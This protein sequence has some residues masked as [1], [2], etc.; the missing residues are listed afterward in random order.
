MRRA[1]R[2]PLLFALTSLG[3]ACS[4]SPQTSSPSTDPRAEQASPVQDT[5]D[6][7]GQWDVVS[8]EN[9]RPQRLSGT[10][11]AAFADFDKGGVRLRIECNYSSRAGR[12][13]GG[14]FRPAPNDDGIQTQM[15]CGTEREAR[16]SRFFAFF[17][18]SPTIERI[19]VD[20]LRL[21]AD[22]TEL[23]LERPA[24][25]RLANA[26]T[27]AEMQGSW[28]MLELTRYLPGGGHS[29][30]GLSDV[31]GRIVIADGRMSYN[32][33]PQYGVAF[34][35][36]EDGRLIKTGGGDLPAAPR[37]CGILSAQPGAPLMPIMWDVLR[38][39]HANPAV[40]RA[41]KNTLLLSTEDVGLLI[42]TAPCRSLEQSE[43][44]KS[45]TV[46]DCASPTN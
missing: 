22:S 33:C 4:W 32:R 30:G 11:R 17:G 9:H 7:A 37:E 5:A 3:V 16:D 43:D 2:G 1:R 6:I 42:T 19:G 24:L 14:R 34:R 41:D 46:R 15:G 39:L 10:T 26:P 27:P 45:S 18:K 40:E 44:H 38:L 36:G 12:V 23:F 20:R 31:P 21:R 13:D 35:I 25:R 29:G 28:R 8:F